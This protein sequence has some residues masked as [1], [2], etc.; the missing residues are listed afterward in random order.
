MAG[1]KTFGVAAGMTQAYDE[2]VTQHPL[3]DWQPSDPPCLQIRRA[4]LLEAIATCHAMPSKSQA[5]SPCGALGASFESL[6][7]KLR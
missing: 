4:V 6:Y 7:W 5:Y 2:I 1:A 3:D